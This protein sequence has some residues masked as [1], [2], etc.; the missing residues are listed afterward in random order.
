MALTGITVFL[1]AF[2]LFLV[3]PIIAKLILPRFGGSVAVWA[4][5]LVFF[6]AVLLLGYA[7]AHHLVQRDRSRALKFMHVALLLGSL[8]L[9]PIVPVKPWPGASASSPALQI[10][11]L[12]LLT[13]GL[14]FTLL[15]MTSP[16]LQAW[17]AA[18]ST[19][20]NP[21]RLFAV[22][23]LAS[24]AALLAYP[25]LIEPWMH[26]A[27]QAI[28]WS[29]AY[30][31]YVLAL[32][33][34][35]LRRRTHVAVPAASADDPAPGAARTLGW[36]AMAALGSYAL[37][38][39]TNHLTQ[40]IPSFPMM[41]VLPLVIY[42][43][44]FT[45][46][47]DGDRWYPPRA[48]RAA[49]LLALAV[50]C[51]VLL[52]ERQVKGIGWHIGTFLI[53]L[54]VVC[55][56]C[57]GELARSRPAPSR[58]TQFYLAV[59]AGGVAGGALVALGAPALLHGYFEVEIG[60]VLLS[61]AVLWRSRG[62]G[63]MWAGVAALVLLATAATAV[64]RVNDALNEVI[65]ISR[66]FYGVVRIREYGRAEASTLERVLIHGRVMHGQQFMA[67]E[68]RRKP[69]SYYAEGSGVGRLLMALADRPIEVGAVGLGAGTI[70]TYGKPGDRY[71]FYEIDEAIVDA[72]HRHFSFVADSP[73]AVE[74]AVGD[75][76]LLLQQEDSRRF[77]VLVVDAFSGDSIPVHLLTREAVMLY[78]ERVKPGG[79]IA[80]HVSNSHLDLRPVVGRIAAELG[81]QLAYIADGGVEG[82]VGTSASDW[83][84]LADDRRVLDLE[85]I[86]QATVPMPE[87]AGARAWS[88]DYSNILQ[89][90]SFGRGSG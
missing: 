13:I 32:C 14:P 81:L 26:T 75:G 63:S 76:R 24:L 65:A 17:R 10:L 80:L 89:V 38:G 42:L 1:S 28:A 37:V 21:Y 87:R 68:R 4:T 2:L 78:R 73:A 34:I 27:T 16:L 8:A 3:Q 23:N 79:V 35:S 15:A 49:T 85:P 54:F 69:T 83:I 6:Q 20:G 86:R 48:Y 55:M 88:D 56:Y 61:A 62:Q 59:S 45:L 90:L 77:D 84:L 25:W 9:L 12:L 5:C 41:W 82:D 44:S 18:V 29:V 71:R 46:C 11:G 72:A 64:I 67:P 74:V 47:F 70:A 51:A 33:A 36:F 66:N 22:S 39:F 43:L 50:M 7:F 40:N 58:L 30:A 52:Q 31:A 60:L 53:G 19:Q 57:H